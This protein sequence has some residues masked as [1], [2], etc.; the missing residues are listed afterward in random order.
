MCPPLPA[1]VGTTAHP[2]SQSCRWTSFPAA[3]AHNKILALHPRTVLR[4]HTRAAT[5]LPPVAACQILIGKICSCPPR[6]SL[7]HLFQ[8]IPHCDWESHSS[9]G[10][11]YLRLAVSG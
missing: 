11:R 4:V 5:A 2:K 6:I 8:T 1:S 9:I 7:L 10:S 3:Q